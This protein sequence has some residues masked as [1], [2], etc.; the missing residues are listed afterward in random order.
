MEEEVLFRPEGYWA[1]YPILEVLVLSDDISEQEYKTIKAMLDS[2]DEEN[3][4]IA[5]IALWEKYK[6]IKIKLK[7]S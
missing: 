3:L 6:Y 1:C 2:S 7:K 5:E 4:A